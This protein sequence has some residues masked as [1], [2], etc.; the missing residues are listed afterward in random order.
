MYFLCAL[1]WH[2]RYSNAITI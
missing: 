1:D 2:T